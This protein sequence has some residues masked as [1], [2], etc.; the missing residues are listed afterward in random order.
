MVY[1]V[2]ISVS[3]E[4]GGKQALASGCEESGAGE[5]EGG[6]GHFLVLV[7]NSLVLYLQ[8]P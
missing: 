1:C 5:V 3:S 2:C 6:G 7:V 8:G 4:M